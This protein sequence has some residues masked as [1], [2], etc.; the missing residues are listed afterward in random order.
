MRTFRDMSAEEGI[1]YGIGLLCRATLPGQDPAFDA[2]LR[3]FEHLLTPQLHAALRAY[4][5]AV[6]ALLA[7]EDRRVSGDLWKDHLLCLAVHKAHAFAQMAAAGGRDEALFANM[8][9]EL[10]ILG[11]LSRLRSEDI[12]RFTKERQQALAL[13]PRQGKDAI[14]VMSTAVWSGANTRPLPREEAE[15][16]SAAAPPPPLL[17]ARFAFTPWA[18]GCGGLADSYAADE[19][20]EEIYLRLLSAQDWGELAEA[21]YGLFETYGCGAFLRR[22][23]FVLS[24]GRLSPLPEAA[25]TPL[26]P[27]S[28]Y[29]RERVA[30]M[31]NTIRF[32]RG[33]YAENALL[34]GGSGTGKTAHVL[35]LLN[36]LPE[37][38]LVLC[39]PEDAGIPALLETLAAQPLRFLL[40]LDDIG[41][42]S[43]A[44][45]AL[46][47]RLC[48]GR[49][50][51]PNVLL[52]A[53]SREAP[54]PASLFS[55]LLP[56]PY[57]SLSAFTS[58]A[59]ELLEAEGICT[60]P[61]ALRDACVDYQ[62]DA[63]ERLTFPGAR[64]VAEAIKESSKP[65]G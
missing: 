50:L 1:S 60:S 33:D 2:L 3:M 21:L 36:E 39:S 40:L 47:A 48:G 27:T 32:M 14:S 54:G 43:S 52:Y 65:L 12:A 15:N 62:V 38:R 37:V 58:L 20:L 10:S 22:R 5:D 59:A 16:T 49:A 23:A 57:P 31:E 55:L 11:E 44:L 26:I 45:R 64:R 28:L 30:L 42:H 4:H 56:F 46:E 8:R 6:A 18:Y 35:S 53:T 41:P 34:Y 7:A 29:E 17:Q 9:E 61:Q 13:R 63:R 24:C 51:P 19:A 25:L